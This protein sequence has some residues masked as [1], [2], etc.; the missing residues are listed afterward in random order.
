MSEQQ[1]PPPLWRV[2]H[3]AYDE[4]A[5]P[6]GGEWTN[7]CGYAAEIRAL[8]DWLVPEEP[9]PEVPDFPDANDMAPWQRW[10]ERKRTRQRLLAE[11]DRAE[12]GE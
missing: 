8:A 1:K 11:A 5:P 12:R 10:H 2:M 9:E 7:S 4:S 6:G 3:R